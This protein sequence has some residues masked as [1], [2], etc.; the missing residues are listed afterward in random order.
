MQFGSSK[1][2]FPWFLILNTMLGAQ[3][4]ARIRDDI[5]LHMET[6]VINKRRVSKLKEHS[7]M[8][9]KAG[10]GGLAWLRLGGTAL[11][12]VLIKSLHIPAAFTNNTEKQTSN[13][14]FPS[15]GHVLNGSTIS[16]QESERG[17]KEW[18]N[19]WMQGGSFSVTEKYLS[20]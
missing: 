5:L 10:H 19:E 12:Q 9:W 18:M 2:L 20:K 11:T 3:S 1:I 17:R 7:V 6:K 14:S 15:L 4:M 8:L 16:P 13:F